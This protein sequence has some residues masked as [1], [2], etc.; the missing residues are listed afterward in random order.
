MMPF[1]SKKKATVRKCQLA[2]FIGNDTYQV[3]F[4]VA[5]VFCTL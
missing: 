2:I 1:V 5:T 3:E 4:I